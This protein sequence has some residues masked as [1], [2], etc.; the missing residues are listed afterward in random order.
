MQ[1]LQAGETLTIGELGLGT[2]LNLALILQA[3]SEHGPAGARCHVITI[4]KH[5]LSRSQLRAASARWTSLSQEFETIL[6]RWPSPIPGCHRRS[7]LIDGLTVDFW[8]EDVSDALGDLESYGNRWIDMWFLDGFTPSRNEAMWTADVLRGVANL[9][10]D[11]AHAPHLRPLATCVGRSSMLAS[12][13][14]S[15]WLRSKAGVPTRRFRPVS[16]I[17]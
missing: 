2:A 8:W 9:S 16:G 15:A 17:K 10:R 13:C 3:W 1:A 4:E 7:E 5:P 11:T 6:Q 14:R 12:R